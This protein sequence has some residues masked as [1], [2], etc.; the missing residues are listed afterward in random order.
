M[1]DDCV[2]NCVVLEWLQN[3]LLGHDVG[4]PANPTKRHSLTSIASETIYPKVPMNSNLNDL[5]TR[6]PLY[7]Q[8]STTASALFRLC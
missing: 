1:I 5:H 2:E 7:L 8:S 3:K 4:L 6:L